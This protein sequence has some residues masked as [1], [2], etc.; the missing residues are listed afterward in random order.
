VA[1]TSTTTSEIYRDNALRHPF[2]SLARAVRRWTLRNDHN[3]THPLTGDFDAD[4]SLPPNLQHFQTGEVLPWKGV[5]FRV[6]KVVGGDFPCII[7][8]PAGITHGTKLRTLKNFRDLNRQ[9]A[10]R[11]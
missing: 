9:E 4:G 1:S 10:R 7:L 11:A 8:V 5:R 2:R 6:G 3:A